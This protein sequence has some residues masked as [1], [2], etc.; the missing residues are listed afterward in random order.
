MT[1]T[2]E[3]LYCVLMASSASIGLTV[4][5]VGGGREE[6]FIQGF[7]H[8]LLRYGIPVSILQF[9]LFWIFGK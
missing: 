3:I 2:D 7:C 5:R 8:S 9:V 1:L 4:L 6:R